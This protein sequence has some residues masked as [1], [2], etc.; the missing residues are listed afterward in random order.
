MGEYKELQDKEAVEKMKKLA[1]D[2]KVCMFCTELTHFPIAARPMSLQQVDDNGNLWFIS[3]KSSN[4]NF[5]I[6][7]D[8]RVQLFFSKLEDSHYLSIAGE[9][10]VYTDRSKIDEI[11]SPVAKAW[12]EKGKDDPDVSVIRVRPTDAYYWDTQNGKAV[13]ML[14]L[15]AA[16]IAGKRIDE[17]GIEGTLH[18]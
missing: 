13:T 15:A 8:N 2:V 5:E 9:A 10:A 18:V 6:S 4:K 14:K 7:H 3:S 11:W 17:G 1:E 16:A 12:F